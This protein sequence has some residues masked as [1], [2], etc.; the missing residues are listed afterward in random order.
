LSGVRRQPPGATYRVMRGKLYE[1]LAGRLRKRG[2]AVIELRRN[3]RG[4][5]GP[6]WEAS[7]VDV[8]TGAQVRMWSLCSVT[9]LVRKPVLLTEPD[10]EGDIR[11]A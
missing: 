9:E 6:A 10:G 7:A 4:G 2:Y 5:P 8:I 3:L 1:R 11:V